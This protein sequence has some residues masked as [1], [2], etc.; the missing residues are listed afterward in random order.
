[1]PPEVTV[2]GT[3][4]AV[5]L[6]CVIVQLTAP[7]AEAVPVQLCAVLPLPS[8]SVTGSPPGPLPAVVLTVP[9]SVIGMPVTAYGG[10]VLVTVVGALVT[11]IVFDPVLGRRHQVAAG[12]PA[13]EASRHG[14]VAG[15][16]VER[17]GAAR[18]A[19]G[20]GGRRA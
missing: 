5:W 7:S 15:G 18:N 13:G 11:T 1:M 12:A 9:V 10:L 17:D 14:V 2:T 20:V 6:G 4:P 19:V 3:V 8:V 16:F